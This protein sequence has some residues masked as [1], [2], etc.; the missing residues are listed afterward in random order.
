MLPE[1]VEILPMRAHHRQREFFGQLSDPQAIRAMFDH[2]PGVYFFVKDLDGRMVAASAAILGRLGFR[3]ESEFIGMRDSDVFPAHLAAAYAE[4][5]AEV[6]RTGR[7]LVDRLELWFD[8]ERQLEWCVTTK[9]P[10]MGRD[11]RVIGLM[12]LTR[13]EGRSGTARPEQLAARALVYLRQRPSVAV[14]PAELARQ[15]AVSERTLHR[16][17]R[18]ALGIAPYELALRVRIQLAAEALVLGIEPIA[19]I[20]QA[21]G[22]CDQSLFTSHF[23]RRMGI[24]PAR[25]RA[26]HREGQGGP[27]VRAQAAASG[28]AGGP[29]K[30]PRVHRA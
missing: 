14:S 30:L 2:V 21:H 15:L 29:M 26:S 17:I 13:R 1:S 27:V 8:E 3:E 24:T 20:A 11:G 6:F 16:R 9:L 23:R 19:D 25:F 10:L 7:P 18:E 28:R 12:G 4:D 5:D 22:F